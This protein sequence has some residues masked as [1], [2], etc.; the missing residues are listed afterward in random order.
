MVLKKEDLK[1]GW[2]DVDEKRPEKDMNVLCAYDYCDIAVA[3]IGHYVGYDDY[4]DGRVYLFKNDDDRYI[5]CEKWKYI[6]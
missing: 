4:S 2:I 5:C 6:E 1:E 3:E